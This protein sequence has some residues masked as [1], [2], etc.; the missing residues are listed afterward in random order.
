MATPKR[1]GLRDPDETISLPGVV[2][3]IVE[4][5]DLTVGRV[6]QEPGWRWSTHVRPQVGGEWCQARHVGVVVSGRFGVVMEDGTE[7]EIG[8]DDVY[9]IPSGHDGYTIGDEP[10][11]LI[12]WHGLRTFAGP[13]AGLHGRTLATLLFTDL[14][15]STSRVVEIGDTAWR[16]L[17]S[18]HYQAARGAL[19]RFRGR[20]V[21]TTGDGMLALFDGP[22]L[23]LR[24]AAA[25][26][27][28]AEHHDLRIRAGVHVG[29]VDLVGAD[30]RGAAVH[31]AARVMGE[32][33]PDEILAS[34]IARALAVASGLSF[35]D[36]GVRELRGLPGERRLFAYLDG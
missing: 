21:E 23:A 36:R 35:E 12:E 32:A 13:R 8:P 10:V 2:E 1:K 16:D 6:V 29:E 20:E 5:G 28:A 24:C 9:D 34:E 31:E 4:L 15:G 22:A 27:E 19:D 3:Q 11:V 18:R 33:G 7:L 17:L 26:R 25:I 30:V 14:V